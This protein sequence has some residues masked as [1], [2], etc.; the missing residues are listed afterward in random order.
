MADTPNP[1]RTLA[2][3]AKAKDGAKANS[4]DPNAATELNKATVFLVPQESERNP[5]GIC[6]IA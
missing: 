4:I 1:T 5:T 6:V 3:I 2:K